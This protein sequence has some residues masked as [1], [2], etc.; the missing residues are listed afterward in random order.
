MPDSFGDSRIKGKYRRLIL[1]KSDCG[2]FWLTRHRTFATTTPTRKN[3]PS[4][5]V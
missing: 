1:T 2:C 3:M 4:G 5:G